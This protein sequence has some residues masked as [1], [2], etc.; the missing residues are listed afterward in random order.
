MAT[1]STLSTAEVI[2]ERQVQ[3]CLNTLAVAVLDLELNHRLGNLFND[4]DNVE[5]ELLGLSLPEAP[6]S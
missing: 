1:A 4:K 5:L 2:A 6:E 3:L